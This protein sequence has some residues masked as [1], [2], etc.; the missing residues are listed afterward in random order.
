MDDA[1]GLCKD[2]IPIAIKKLNS[3]KVLKKSRK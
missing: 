2:H 3:V 1:I